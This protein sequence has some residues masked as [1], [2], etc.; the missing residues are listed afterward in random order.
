MSHFDNDE[1]TAVVEAPAT[2]AERNRTELETEGLAH[3]LEIEETEHDEVIETLE[4]PIEDDVVR[5]LTHKEEAAMMGQLN[6]ALEEEAGME[7]SLS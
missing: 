1:S 3:V 4:N 2:D 6:D 5:V 7:G